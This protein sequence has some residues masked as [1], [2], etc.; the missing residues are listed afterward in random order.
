MR[1]SI[2][3]IPTGCRPGRSRD[4]RR[5]SYNITRMGKILTTARS[6]QDFR[7]LRR[8]NTIVDPPAN[9]LSGQFHPPLTNTLR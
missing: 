7:P 9:P 8:R 1:K 4:R 5:T 2:P 3:F 6:R